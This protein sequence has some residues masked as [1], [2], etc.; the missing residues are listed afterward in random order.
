MLDINRLTTR[1]N[2]GRLVD[3]RLDWSIWSGKTAVL[4]WLTST[5]EG[6]YYTN[7]SSYIWITH[8]SVDR[9]CT[10]STSRFRPKLLWPVTFSGRLR[11]LGMTS[12]DLLNGLGFRSQNP[13]KKQS[14]GA[15]PVQDIQYF[16]A[17]KITPFGIFLFHM[18][19]ALQSWSR[20]PFSC[21][22]YHELSE[23]LRALKVGNYSRKV[24]CI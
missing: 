17:C 22:G 21:N 1:I 5:S 23:D 9:Q 6:R 18:F 19:F 15:Y 4:D 8:Y 12:C 7:W 16:F 24:P 14:K 13:A 11:W 3:S 20:Q 10:E 2:H